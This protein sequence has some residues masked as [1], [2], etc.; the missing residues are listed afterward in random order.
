M[1]ASPA[2]PPAHR[3][4]QRVVLLQAQVERRPRL[5]A[6]QAL[7]PRPGPP[8]QLPIG[9]PGGARGQP[10]PQVTLRPGAT[11]RWPGQVLPAAGAGGLAEWKNTLSLPKD[12][13]FLLFGLSG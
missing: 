13:R 9:C 3:T 8:A 5:P 4:Q 10:P 7:P 1:L 6:R 12:E 2:W 11:A